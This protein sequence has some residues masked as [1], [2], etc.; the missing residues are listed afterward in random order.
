MRRAVW[1]AV[2]SNV[3]PSAQSAPSPAESTVGLMATDVGQHPFGVGQLPAAQRVVQTGPV[4]READALHH[5]QRDDVGEERQHRR[6]GERV[7]GEAQPEAHP[8]GLPVGVVDDV[9]PTEIGVAVP[10]HRRGPVATGRDVGAL[11]WP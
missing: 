5:R 1:L 7:D 6:R 9:G 11:R 2:P 4:A 10:A 3:P 8:A